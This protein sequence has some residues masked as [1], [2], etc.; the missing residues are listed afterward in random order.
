MKVK[1]GNGRETITT[2]AHTDKKR[3]NMIRT[4]LKNEKYNRTQIQKKNRTLIH[5]DK[6]DYHG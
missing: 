5:A 6:A 3:K 4:D 1:W 2:R